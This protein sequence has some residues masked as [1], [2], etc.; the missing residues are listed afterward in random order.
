MEDDISGTWR[1]AMA[2]TDG[3]AGHVPAA[4]ELLALEMSVVM[5]KH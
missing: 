2:D 1:M 5:S 3:M 4:A